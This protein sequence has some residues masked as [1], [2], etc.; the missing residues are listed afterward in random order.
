MQEEGKQWTVKNATIYVAHDRIV[1]MVNL[2]HSRSVPN[3]HFGFLLV[4]YLIGIFTRES[5]MCGTYIALM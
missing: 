2:D 4:C 5:R 1:F 3:H